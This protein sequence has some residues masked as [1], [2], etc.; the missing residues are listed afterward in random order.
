MTETAQVVRRTSWTTNDV[1][2]I[3]AVAKS[4]VIRPISV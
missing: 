1:M 4:E 3:P 2:I